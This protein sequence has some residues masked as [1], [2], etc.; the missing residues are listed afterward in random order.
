MKRL[1]TIAAALLGGM[2]V[3]AAGAADLPRLEQTPC[4]FDVPGGHEAQCAYLYVAEDRS[5]ASGSEIRLPVARLMT[6]GQ[7]VGNDPILFI[8]GGPGGDAGLDAK[9]IEDWWWYVDNTAWM[10]KRDFIL[11]D[12]RGTGL[13]R[14]NLNC[15]E[16]DRDSAR[17]KSEQ[18][19]FAGWIEEMLQNSD[20]CRD[21]LLAE[22]R[23]LAAY[24]SKSAAE[25]IVDLMSAADIESMNIYGASYGTR[26]AFSLLR[27]HPEQV[28]SLVL[29]S[30]LPPNADLVIQQ[31]V[32]FGQVIAHVAAGCAADAACNAKYP[33]LEVRFRNRLE[34]LNRSPLDIEIFN[35]A[36]RSKQNYPLIGVDIVDLLF[37][38]MYGSE[39]LRYLPT[40]LD[41]LSRGN[42]ASLQSWFQTYRLRTAGPDTTSEG[43]YYAFAC[44]EQVA[45][46]D[47]K[48]AAAAA[49]EYSLYND[50]GLVGFS[51]YLTCPRWPV[52]AVDASE[53]QPVVSDKPVLLLSGEYDPVTPAAFAEMAA[54]TLSQSY[55]FILPDA[56]HA[57]LS[58]SLCANEIADAFLDDPTQRP[59]AACLE[60][61]N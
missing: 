38:L 55:H 51:D 54:A 36:S 39:S 19:G 35:P 40:L 61:S 1:F 3:S 9:S 11:M 52:P 57:P 34:D 48:T 13:T 33:D 47:M 30:V 24:N 58:H 44:S 5:G 14:P 10:R 60:T 46:V 37:D 49:A 45:Y 12:V 17:S 29:E 56:G 50:D 31:Q 20:D 8:N 18:R 7:T 42:E 59:S 43:V 26:I 53:R 21:R 6:P 16:M 28:R 2:A 27:D 41:S 15:P 23:H 22:G 4:W 25:D 32:G